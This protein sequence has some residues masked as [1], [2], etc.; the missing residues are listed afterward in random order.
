MSNMAQQRQP[1]P[2]ISDINLPGKSDISAPRWDM[3][4]DISAYGARVS[5]IL[6]IGAAAAEPPAAGKEAGR[7]E[8]ASTSHAGRFTI[9]YLDNHSSDRH[10]F[11]GKVD[12]F[13][14]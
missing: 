12:Y 3:Q 1:A 4:P 6:Y 10:T 13:H 14:E 2:V 7:Q 8:T 9:R 11:F 5:A